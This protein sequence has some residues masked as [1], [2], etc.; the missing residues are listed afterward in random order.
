MVLVLTCEC[1]CLYSVITI[2][3]SESEISWSGI[4]LVNPFNS[5]FVLLE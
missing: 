4:F 3:V 5:A 1:L 2:V